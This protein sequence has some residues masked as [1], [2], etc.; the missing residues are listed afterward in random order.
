MARPKHP[1]YQYLELLQDILK[2]G[3]WKK[4]HSTGVGLKSVFGRQLRWDLSRGFPLLTTKK[5]YFRGIVHELIWFLSGSSNV[6]YLIDNNVHIWD[7]YPYKNYK[8]QMERGKVKKMEFIDFM[9]KMKTD[10]KFC[11]KWGD[12]GPVYGV[13]WRRWPAGDGREIDQLGWVINKMKK[14]PQ[15]KHFLVSSWNAGHIY[16]MAKERNE[17]V[18]IAPCHTLFHIVLHGGKL[19]LQLYQ[20]SADVFLGVPFNIASYALLTCMLAQVIGYEP[21]TFV[22]TFGDVHIY[23]D[24]F[25]QVREQLKRKPYPFPKLKLNPKI[26]NIDDFKFDD[27]KIENYRFHPSIKAS[28]TP[29]GGF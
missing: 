12:I 25:K 4:S 10:S 24:H 13:Q 26:K 29:V 22:H 6:K 9:D 20:R 17:S 16:E 2:N 15:K 7:D 18:A 21:G 27:V 5:T 23:E 1:E 3:V 14:L 19:N 8:Y 11:K 28:L